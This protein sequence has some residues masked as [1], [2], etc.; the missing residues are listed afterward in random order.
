MLIMGAKHSVSGDNEQS[1]ATG[2]LL[3]CLVDI[4]A[5]KLQAD[6]GRSQFLHHNFLHLKQYN[7]E[8]VL[9]TP[10]TP[11]PHQL[12]LLLGHTGDFALSL[13]LSGCRRLS[14]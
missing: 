4:T 10:W 7:N 2:L 11:P 12:A 8:N 6:A 3:L 5:I 13:R 14:N 1:M 9:L